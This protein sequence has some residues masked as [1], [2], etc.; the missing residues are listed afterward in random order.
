MIKAMLITFL[1]FV[2]LGLF[3]IL[4]IEIKAKSMGCLSVFLLLID[5]ATIAAI[6][7]V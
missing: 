4:F 7:T 3:L 5:V 2:G 1:T 6:A